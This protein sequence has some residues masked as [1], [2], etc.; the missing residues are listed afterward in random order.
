MRLGAEAVVS[1][2]YALSFSVYCAIAAFSA[3]IGLTR[4]LERYGAFVLRTLRL[5]WRYSQIPRGIAAM[6]HAW[7][8]RVLRRALVRE[9][10]G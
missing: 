4:L 5:A 9:L 6:R 3:R 2:G 8:R 1:R 7:D 10:Y